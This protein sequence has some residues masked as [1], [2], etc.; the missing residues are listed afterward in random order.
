MST[1]AITLV[2]YAALAVMAVVLA[3]TARRRPSTVARMSTVV[4]WMMSLGVARWAVLVL[5]L[6]LGWHVF[7]R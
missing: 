7:V 5:W 2:G 4:T 6:W 3:I 1:A